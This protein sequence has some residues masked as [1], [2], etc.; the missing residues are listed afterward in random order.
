MQSKKI[1]KSFLEFFKNKAHTILPSASLIPVQDETLLFTNAGMNQFK[2]VFLGHGSRNYKRV[3]NSQ[4]CIRVSG[5][6]NDLEDVGHD[7][8]HHTFFEMLGNW[9]FGDYFKKEAI[10]LAWELLT[11]VWKLPK[12]R[13]WATVYKP[14]EESFNYWKTETN[15]DTSHILRFGEKENFWDMGETGPCGPCSEI[16]IDLTENGCNKSLINANN[17]D[18]LELWN[19]VF[20]Q[21][22]RREDGSLEELPSMHVDTGMGLERISRVLQNVSSNYDTD[23]FKPIVEAVCEISEKSYRDKYVVSIQVIVDHIR[24]LVFAIAD[25]VMPSNEGRGYVL[26]RLIRRASRRGNVLQLNQPFLYRLV[27]SVVNIMKDAYPEL[28]TQ[29]EHISLI[30]KSEEE[31][32]QKTLLQGINLFQE[33]VKYVKKDKKKLI[34]GESAFRLYDTFG[35]PIDLTCEMAREQ[36]LKVDIEEFN[37]EMA[38][39][40]QRSIS[41]TPL[42]SRVTVFKQSTLFTGYSKYS[43]KAQILCILK[44]GKKTDK[45]KQ[46]D[47]IEL[48]LDKT[49]FYAESGGQIG[50]TGVISREDCDIQIKD[51][52]KISDT[53]IHKAKI[54]KGTIKIG[55]NVTASIDIARRM[56]IAK[57]HSSAHLLQYALRQVLGKHIQQAG[58][59]VGEKRMRF[60]FNHFNAVSNDQL[61]SI[62]EIVNQKI[63]ELVEVKTFNTSMKKAKELGAIALFN[64]KYGETVRVV[65]IGDFSVELCGGTHVKNTGEIGLF[66]IISDSSIASGV[67]RIE[68]SCGEAAYN[69]MKE[70]QEILA[71]TSHL[72]HAPVSEISSRVATLIKNHKELEKQ[73]KKFKSKQVMTNIDDFIKKA[74]TVNN[75]KLVSASLKNMGHEA[76]RDIADV[77]KTKLGSSAVVVLGSVKKNKVCLVTAVTSD[78]VSKG[79]HAGRIIK[80]IAQITGGSG[81]GRPD[82]AQAGGKDVSKLDQALKQVPEIIREGINA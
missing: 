18:V 29:R 9:S 63:M 3:A 34:S 71:E 64:E 43:D 68:A 76:L 66:R 52:Y 16:H 13:L 81:G 65:R 35:F 53:F 39:Q 19:L 24:A 38:K 33:L 25:G 31:R 6:H 27:G 47:D 57:H 4:K 46:Q 22:N 54:S 75:V 78:L 48:I 37:R 26:R 45:A 28:E 74:I 1:R 44:G 70:E 58:S 61:N 59:W 67:R 40:R 14:D 72:L 10:S 30:L 51:T 50:D 11:E 8:H 17:P 21:H 5:K 15:I 80:E 2:D 62:E 32:F 79:L 49:C 41:Q 69:I 77:L 82:M 42:V 20:I 56:R 12:E 23:L 7:S 36:G 60:D 55:D 73:S